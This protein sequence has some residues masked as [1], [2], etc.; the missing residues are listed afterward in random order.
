MDGIRNFQVQVHFTGTSYLEAK[1][2]ELEIRQIRWPKHERSVPVESISVVAVR[3]SR[4]A[5]CARTDH[6][7]QSSDV[8]LKRVYKSKPINNRRRQL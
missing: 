7:V 4:V 5:T 2:Y 6:E 1:A 3:F 8:S